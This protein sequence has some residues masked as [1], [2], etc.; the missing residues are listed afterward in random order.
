VDFF[1][2]QKKE[3]EQRLSIL[4]I[5]PFASRTYANDLAVR[6]ILDL[7]E[8]TWFDELTF[9]IVG[10]GPLFDET[11]EPLRKFPNITLQKRF[12]TREQILDLHRSSGVFLVPTRL[13]SQGVSRDEAMSSGLVPITCAVS[14]VP[15]FVDRDSGILVGQEDWKGLADAIRLLRD[16]PATFER[17]SAGAAQRVRLQSPARAVAAA[18]VEL[19]RDD[20]VNSPEAKS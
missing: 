6:A 7:S 8:E 4:S 16:S 10:D 18:E 5:R 2:T 11:V 14:A 19:M 3:V 12:L 17:L 9:T 20:H 1:Q 15:E 13:D